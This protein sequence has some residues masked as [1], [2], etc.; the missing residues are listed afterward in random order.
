MLEIIGRHVLSIPWNEGMLKGLGMSSLPC[1]VLREPQ[2][3]PDLS[4]V[5]SPYSRASGA[6]NTEGINSW[7]AMPIPSPVRKVSEPLGL[8]AF[9][10]VGQSQLS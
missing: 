7:K 6:L 5:Q 3:L 8:P 4:Q 10:H 2:Q 9:N 1:E